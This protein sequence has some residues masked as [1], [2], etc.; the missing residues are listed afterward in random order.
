MANLSLG[1]P[2][3]D[4]PRNSYEYENARGSHDDA[5]MCAS[6][7]AQWGR[8]FHTTTRDEV[9]P[10]QYA[11]VMVEHISFGGG[12]CPYDDKGALFL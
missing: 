8:A 9:G 5:E 6:L 1:G 12:E 4:G 11:G 10:R 3:H 7:S 2:P